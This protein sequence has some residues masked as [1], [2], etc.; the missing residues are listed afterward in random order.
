MYK[1]QVLAEDPGDSR[2]VVALLNGLGTVKYEELYVTYADVARLLAERG[3]EVVE[4]EVGEQCTS[5]DM[6]GLSL[7]VLWLDDELER[8]WTAPCDTPAYRKGVVGAREIDTAAAAA[9]AADEEAQAQIEPGSEA[10][11]GRCV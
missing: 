5:L 7:T 10:S 4:A 2:R 8:L 3:Y 9:A 11:Q 6:A 1:R